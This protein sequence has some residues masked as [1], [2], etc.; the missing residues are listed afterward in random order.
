[1]KRDLGNFTRGSQLIEH[2]GFMFAAGLKGPLIISLIVMCW[3]TWW[4]VSEGMSDHEVYLAWMHV[5]GAGY[6]FM[7]F[8]PAHD[9]TVRT[10]WGRAVTF[11]ISLLDIYP[12][13]VR[14]WHHL[15]KL[16]GIALAWSTVI[17][18]PVF[19][20]WVWFASR[21]GGKAKERQHERGARLTTL[22]DLEARIR[23]HN[24]AEQ[25]KE[26]SAKLG[27]E[28]RFCSTAELARAFPYRP[29]SI[30]GVTYPWRLE[31][32]HAMLIGTTGMGKTARNFGGAIVTGIHAYA[33]L[34]EV[35]GDNMAMTLSSLARTKLVLGTGDADTA[36][37]CSDFIGQREVRD[38]DEGYTYGFNN[39]RDAV[40]LTTRRHIQRLLLPDDIKDLPRLVGYLKF[41]DGFPAAEVKLTPVDRPMRSKAFI[42]R[43]VDPFPARPI[44]RE[45]ADGSTCE[46]ETGSSAQEHP[47]SNDD[48]AGRRLDPR[49]GVLPLVPREPENGEGDE[50]VQ[51][52]GSLT[53]QA[54]EIGTAKGDATSP[55]VPREGQS[56]DEMA[57]VQGAGSVPTRGTSPE[58]AKASGDGDLPDKSAPI[59]GRSSASDT[60]PVQSDQPLSE[61]PLALTDPRRMALEG[62]ES[63]AHRAPREPRDV[64]EF[65]VEI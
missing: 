13:V 27:N 64:G 50:R 56:A 8:D 37:W 25:R 12:P 9:V 18:V 60:T 29:S 52:R 53:D 62:D 10:A 5:Y 34:K 22:R 36:T 6:R 21:F 65:D 20:A 32:S 3:M 33:K 19:V 48:G 24:K 14:A 41:P 39:A 42:R 30:A 61:A 46:D 4:T 40:S 35:Y 49:Q 45:L 28:W 11:P 44:A 23:R 58:A 59:Y 7:E 51:H 47:S 16:V 31:Q 15:L 57:G 55:G 38:M 43:A 54:A 2:F 17:L 63:E 1:M 26:W